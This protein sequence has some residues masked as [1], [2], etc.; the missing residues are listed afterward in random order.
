MSALAV[1]VFRA[2]WLTLPFTAGPLF[3][4]ALDPV[5]GLFLLVAGLGSWLVWGLVLLASLVPHTVTL[6]ALRIAAPASLAAAAWAAVEAD[7]AGVAVA[8]LLAT[9]AAAVLSLT[10][11][12]GARFVDGTS[13]GDERR[14]PLRPPAVLLAGPIPLSWAAAVVGATAGPLLL[15]VEQWVAGAIV[16]A[17]GLVVA[18]VAVRALHRLARRWLVFVPAGVVIHDRMALSEPTLVP[19][20]R[21][22]ALGLAPAGTAAEDLTLGASGTPLRLALAEPM[23]LT[24][25]EAFGREAGERV[26]ATELLVAPT[27]PGLA[28][29]IAAERG[30]PIG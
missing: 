28:L 2:V 13:Y 16:T 11:W 22:V 25:G 27:L 4:E 6:T 21:M 26:K 24:K 18:V 9:G 23:E 20:G 1:W 30:L 14:L 12:I 8:G 10:P 19:S 5:S 29:R 3:G 7:S 15:A 17:V